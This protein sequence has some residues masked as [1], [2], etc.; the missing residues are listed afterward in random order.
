MPFNSRSG[1]WV[2]TT[3]LAGVPDTLAVLLLAAPKMR[4]GSVGLI[5]VASI[6]TTTSSVQGGDLDAE[7]RY[8]QFAMR[9]DQGAKL[10]PCGQQP[11]HLRIVLILSF[12][13]LLAQ[14]RVLHS[15]YTKIYNNR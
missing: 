4:P 11:L 8:F 3:G 7:Q 5:G 10:K 2:L 6:R 9:F 13:A 14:I 15:L 12:D 1:I